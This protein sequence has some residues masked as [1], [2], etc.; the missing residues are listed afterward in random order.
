MG[1]QG[2]V[3]VH[4]QSPTD[5]ET[6]EEALLWEPPWEVFPLKVFR[7]KDFKVVEVK[8]EWDDEDLL[9]ALKKTYDGL[10]GFRKFLGLKDVGHLT[11]V[12][13]DHSFI[14]PQR[15]GTPWLS[16]H[17]NMRMCYLLDNP[18]HLRSQRQIMTAL[19]KRV[20]LGVEFVERWK[21]RRLLCTAGVCCSLAY[22]LMFA[23]GIHTGDWATASQ[24]GQFQLSIFALLF[25]AVGWSTYQDF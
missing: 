23:W 22:I 19:T 10:R 18:S 9:I 15:L 13:A 14:Y 12:R 17:K 2:V 6:D 11:I 5:V 4:V 3:P 1:G 16:P 24:M 21:T 8:R 20:D 25:V 7:T